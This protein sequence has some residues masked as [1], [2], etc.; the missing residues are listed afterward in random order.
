MKPVALTLG[1]PSGIGGQ[2]SIAAW[3]ALKGRVPF[4]LIG[5]V[6][7]MR[8]L[9]DR[10]GSRVQPIEEPGQIGDGDPTGLPVL[11]HHLPAEAVPGAPDPA[12]A[13][14]VVEI[15]E[16]AVTLTNSGEACAVCTN[17]ISKH[18]LRSDAGF[19]FPGH[20]E[21]LG[22]LC[23]V[24]TPVMMLASTLLRVV[25]VTIHEALADVPKVLTP[26]LLENTIRTTHAGLI[27]DFGIAKPRI[28]VA[29]L[30][31]H[32][33][34]NG[35][36][37]REEIELIAPVLDH[38]RGEGMYL[39]GPLSADTLFHTAARAT[40]DTAVCMY[41]DQALIPIKALDFDGG[42]N[43]TLGLGMVR[44]SP[45]HGTAYAL[46][47]KNQANPSSLIAAL[48]LAF[49]LGQRRAGAAA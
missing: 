34:E 38:L 16:R 48:R 20:T 22:H 24:E 12:N 21:F 4:F 5:S 7:H 33:G 3:E 27:S 32:A 10:M 15:I 49:E 46:A 39:N 35:T 17:P 25:P 44:T 13:P 11:H 18:V 14:A 1:D 43:V 40:Y 8:V 41:H 2:I 28:A 29:G 37:G 42:V 30:N 45:D 19:G 23:G 47:G 6:D 26:E 36:M 31:P 9:A